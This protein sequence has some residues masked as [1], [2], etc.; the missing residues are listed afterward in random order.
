MFEEAGREVNGLVL[1][2]WPSFPVTKLI[3]SPG[4][5]N[6]SIA[7]QEYSVFVEIDDLAFPVAKDFGCRQGALFFRGRCMQSGWGWR[8]VHGNGAERREGLDGNID[9]GL[10]S[11]FNVSAYLPAVLKDA[12]QRPNAVM[13]VRL[14]IISIGSLAFEDVSLRNHQCSLLIVI[15]PCVFRRDRAYYSVV[16]GIHEEGWKEIRKRHLASWEGGSAS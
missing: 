7:C 14:L 8:S 15:T 5:V 6:V 13:D 4:V 10:R 16:S 9:H 3:F 1:D 11:C 2:A 12:V